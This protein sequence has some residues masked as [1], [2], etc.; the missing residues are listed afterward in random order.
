M[1]KLILPVAIAL[2]AIASCKETEYKKI[3]MSQV[4]QL[5]DSVTHIIAGVATYH[6]IQKE[7]EYTSVKIMIGDAEF[8]AVTPEAKQQAA[9]RVGLALL[10]ILGPDNNIK[11]ATLSVTKSMG[12][13][14]THEDEIKTEIDMDALNKATFPAKQ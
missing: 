1:K 4:D 13:E 14:D 5:Q 10:R 7:G 11:K 12:S 2:M 8:Y 6:V 3:E 9:N